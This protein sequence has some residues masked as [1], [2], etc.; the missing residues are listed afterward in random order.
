[1]ASKNPL[2]DYLREMRDLRRSGSGVAENSYYPALWQL[3]DEVSA[4]LKPKVK[5][6]LQ[7]SHGAGFPDGGLFTPD[8]F[9]KGPEPASAPP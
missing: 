1:V 4:T 5:C 6:V 2:E 8:Q 7:V 3:L 9:Q